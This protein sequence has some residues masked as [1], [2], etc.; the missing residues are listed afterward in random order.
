MDIK[1]EAE[2]AIQQ[3]KELAVN[4]GDLKDRKKELNN[5]IKAEEKALK[6]LQKA[7]A[8]G[9]ASAKQVTAQ[10]EKLARI[11]KQNREEMALLDTALRGN[12]S[13]T[14]ELSNDVAKL[15]DNGLRFRD[16]MGEAFT[17]A[18]ETLIAPLRTQIREA[19]L[20]AQRAFETFGAGSDEFKKAAE[21]ADDLID[22]Q[23]ALNVTINAIDTE[24]KIETFGKSLQG[25]A[26]A[27]SIA[28]GAAAL[29]GT[30]NQAVEEA[31]LKVQAAMAIQQGI[32]GL[33]EGAKAAK[34]L[35]LSLGLVGPAAQAGTAGINGMRAA[36]IASGI[37]AAVV[38]IGTL[39]A[40]ML[41][42]AD[43]TE[44]AKV[45]EEGRQKV[46]AKVA[47]LKLAEVTI[48]EELALLK[49]QTTQ[50]DI[51][52]ARAARES[53]KSVEEEAKALKEAEA[54]YKKNEDAIA[55]L[56]RSNELLSSSTRE[57]A[58]LTLASNAKR[59]QDLQAEQ[60]ELSKTID[61]NRQ[62]LAQA[63][64]N[65]QKTIEV[66]DL[67]AQ[68]AGQEK[69]NN[70]EG[71][72]NLDI[73]TKR[74]DATED[75][76]KAQEEYN[77]KI[78]REIE[79]RNI[80]TL[81]DQLRQ[82]ED[83]LNEFYDSQLTA[84]QQEENAARDSL[85]TRIELAAEGSAERL[86]LEE[87]LRQKLDA[88]AKKY[89]AIETDDQA[90]KL[91]RL[92]EFQDAQLEAEQGL[93]Q[94]RIDA[95]QAITNVL[96]GLAEEGSN[97]AKA[98]FAL[99]KAVAIGNVIV[100]LQRQLTAIRTAAELQKVTASAAGPLAP[101]LI[102]AI[103]AKT[104]ADIARAKV[105]A[106]TSIAVIGAQAIRGFADGGYTGPGGKY[107]PAGIVHRGEYVLPQEVVRAI[108][109]D[110]LDVLRD[111][112][113]NQAPGRGRY[114]TGGLV[115]ATLDSGSIFAANQAAAAN[116][117]NLQ[118]VLPIE[119]LRAVQNRVAVREARSTL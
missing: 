71:Q 72:K 57:G 93:A 36:L 41:T 33:I 59:I 78:Q 7:H 100:Q 69:V 73:T 102:A 16:K 20:E 28:Q 112:Y 83:A 44:K 80:E 2:Q 74:V 67:R 38:L 94:A 89:D 21:K 103:E 62:A 27:F 81:N 70:D 9:E 115:Q 99:E 56:K 4:T 40:N 116:T 58:A 92:K 25:V 104:I 61:I 113:T 23:K 37:G 6:E 88:I 95:A 52:K 22:K 29:F 45:A 76:T 17:D 55:G 101:A 84:R 39:A 90:K 82:Q 75:L 118:P 15:T 65:L 119:S 111:M 47:E 43:N 63:D 87:A 51:D 109:V 110:R 49:G 24:G 86:A 34:G 13:R 31:L 30:E 96:S 46:A 42:L 35:A 91:E 53:A 108:G 48:E 14:R 97:A 68:Q 54:Q 32:S 19:R 50:Q 5:E 105:S 64:E 79:L 66:I 11:R 12:S 60:S 26:G 1:L 77:A 98:F 8:A 18:A 10:E 85:F 117:M 107:E 106:G 114:A 3:L